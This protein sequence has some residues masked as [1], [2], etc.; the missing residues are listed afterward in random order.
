MICIIDYGIGNLRSIEKAF[1][2]VGASVV[3]SD[4]ISELERASHI[5]L[6]GV[7]A[8]GA[9]ADEVRKRGLIEPIKKTI[10]EGKPFLGVCVGMQLLFELSEEMGEHAGIGILPGR[11][12]RFDAQHGEGSR[13]LKIPHM[14]W[15]RLHLHRSSALLEGLSEDPF[16]Y[17]VHSFHASPDK[18][19]DIL[20]SCSYGIDFPA[21]V[22]RNNVFGVQFHPEK[23][24][25]NGLQILRN[26]STM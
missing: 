5:V 25:Q 8:F 2:A 9:C 6:P 15:N 17:F 13:P 26:F 20:A 21:I 23:S 22:E 14:G 12:V 4:Q 3:R 10:A 1:E 11:V 16:F 19:S 7:G 18:D 24:H